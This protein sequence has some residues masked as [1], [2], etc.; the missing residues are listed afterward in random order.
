MRNESLQ[1]A[2][3]TLA[4]MIAFLLLSGTAIAAPKAKKDMPKQSQ[5]NGPVWQAPEQQDKRESVVIRELRY[6]QG[7]NLLIVFG[8]PDGYGYPPY[9]GYPGR[10][11]NPGKHYGHNIRWD[12]NEQIVIRD[13]FGRTYNSRVM[14]SDRN[15]LE[16]RIE[17]LFGGAR[18]SISFGGVFLNE[19][20]Y[21]V[22]G[23]FW[24]KDKWKYKK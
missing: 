5:Q 16:L 8:Y 2:R 18:Y 20:K 1:K 21:G 14:R 22:N 4:L 3:K 10:P 15:V 24:A 19:D 17:G 9:P 6:T 13:I 7:G 11:G 23:E 12:K